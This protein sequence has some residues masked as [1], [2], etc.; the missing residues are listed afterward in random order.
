MQASGC[1]AVLRRTNPAL[2]IAPEYAVLRS[3]IKRGAGQAMPLH[4]LSPTPLPSAPDGIA[5]CEANYHADRHTN[6]PYE[7][8]PEKVM[9]GEVFAK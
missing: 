1:P 2:I 5:N 3:F 7:A 9:R 8:Q 6:G 4:R